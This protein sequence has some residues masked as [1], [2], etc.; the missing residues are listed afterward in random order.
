MDKDALCSLSD[1][2]IYRTRLLRAG[3]HPKSDKCR[4]VAPGHL[5]GSCSGDGGR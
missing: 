5:T 3:R 2:D 1:Q 4:V